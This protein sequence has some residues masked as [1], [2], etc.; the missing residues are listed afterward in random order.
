MVGMRDGV[1]RLWGQDHPSDC[2]LNFGLVLWGN[3]T[4]WAPFEGRSRDKGN[5][6]P[7]YGSYAARLHDDANTLWVQHS[8]RSVQANFESDEIEKKDQ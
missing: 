1:D 2:Q 8:Y 4:F 6:E 5:D 3:V 7:Y